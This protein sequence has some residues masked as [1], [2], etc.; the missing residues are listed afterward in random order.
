MPIQRMAEETRGKEGQSMIG[1]RGILLAGTIMVVVAVCV[2]MGEARAANAVPDEELA[3]MIGAN[4]TGQQCYWL[5]PEYCAA[6]CVASGDEDF[7]YWP[8][9]PSGV[10]YLCGEGYWGQTCSTWLTQC[11][12]GSYCTAC[13]GLRYCDIVIHYRMEPTCF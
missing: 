1:K 12:Q 10:I 4:Q 5:S 6:D 8:R 2:C 7:P 11:A 3:G 9:T 13:E